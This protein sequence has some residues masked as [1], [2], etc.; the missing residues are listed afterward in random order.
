MQKKTIL[1][2]STLL[3]LTSCTSIKQAIN[4][5]SDDS[6]LPHGHDVEHH[7]IYY[8]A[9]DWQYD[10]PSV[11]PVFL[12]LQSAQEY[13]A[14]NNIVDGVP[15]GHEYIVRVVNHRYEV[16]LQDDVVDDI[17]F[18]STHLDPAKKYVDTYSEYHSDLFIYDL[19][20]GDVVSVDT[21]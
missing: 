3:S 13:A 16:R 1:A 11:N 18:T 5:R 7:T 21:P 6:A 19:V 4:N 12:N 10:S 15:T 9:Y 2:I 20:S 14:G 17:L 8:Q